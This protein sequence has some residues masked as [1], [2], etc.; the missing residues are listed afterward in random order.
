V[1]GA[2]VLVAVVMFAGSD[3]YTVS[4]T[5]DNAGQLVRGNQVQVGGRP[6]GT[7]KKIELTDDGRAR[8]EFGIEDDLTPLHQ[9]TR[10]TI[11]AGSLSGIANRFVAIS[12]GPSNAPEIEDGG[13]I[14]AD[15]ASAPVDLDQVFNTL[16]PETRK[17]LQQFVQGS[18]QLYA[19][20][21]GEAN[22]TYKYLNP[23][24]STS[25]RV[26]RELVRDQQTFERFIVDTADLVSAIA[27][28]RNDLSAL[29]QNANVTTRA[30][31][32]ENV[33]L[34]RALGLLPGALRK[35]NTTFVNLRAALDDL[36][37][38]V[39]ESKPATRRLAPFLRKLRPLVADARP[40]IRD[41][42]LLIR[43]SGP[44]N[45][46]IE[47]TR[48]MP[49]LQQIAS[50]TFPRDIRALQKTL[51]VIEYARPYVPDLTGW[52]DKFGHGAAN[53]DANGHFA[54]IQPLFNQFSFTSNP[55]GP[56][57]T[58]VPAT[59]RLAGFQTRR[60]ERCPGGAVQPPPDGSAPF[61]P[62]PDFDCDPNTTP[63]G[64]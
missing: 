54:R 21:G 50:E 52:F 55:A 63:P 9:G 26:T 17:A 36:D 53:Y 58:A 31:G 40:T 45:D 61:R 57:L 47:L 32:D 8:V 60:S 15:N 19:D 22:R 28:R 12:P 7:V 20:K 48:K 4:A 41:L 6:V 10:A 46:L 2:A 62:S 14:A 51:P 3:A 34:A 59:N 1:I 24:L 38:L 49:R 23:A 56:V 37:T 42:R 5:F 18:A 11:R 43:R 27:E 16:D 64:P 13:R 30:I 35:G 33:A 44:N 39:A 25:S 29:V